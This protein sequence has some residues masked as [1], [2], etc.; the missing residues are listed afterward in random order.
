[1]N[2]CMTKL[3][4]F[5]DTFTLNLFSVDGEDITNITEATLD[6]IF[7]KMEAGPL[8]LTTD[9]GKLS[10][11][12]IIKTHSAKWGRVLNPSIYTVG[13]TIEPNPLSLY[14][15]EKDVNISGQLV[16]HNGNYVP[17]IHIHKPINIGKEYD[18]SNFTGNKHATRK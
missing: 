1:M 3:H 5:G 2:H 7:K 16:L 11:G 4:K 9:V 18:L 17:V 13:I 15:Y 12:E 6:K 14:L 8:W 10:L